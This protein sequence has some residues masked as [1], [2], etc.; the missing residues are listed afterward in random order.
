MKQ[1]LALFLAHLSIRVTE[2]EADRGEEVALAGSIATDNH[3]V[4]RGKGLDDRLILIATRRSAAAPA[5]SHDVPFEPLDD[6]LFDVHGGHA[7]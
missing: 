2:Y 7:S 3:I 4:F 1:C 6:D 5:S